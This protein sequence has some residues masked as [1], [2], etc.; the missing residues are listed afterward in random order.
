MTF[1]MNLACEQAA[2]IFSFVL[3][4]GCA[5]VGTGPVPL[6]PLPP[7]PGP[8]C[9]DSRTDPKGPAECG[10]RLDAYV[11]RN[12]AATVVIMPIAYSER[13]GSLQ[14]VGTGAVISADGLVLTAYHVIAGAEYIT[15]EIRSANLDQGILVI[16][17]KTIPMEIVGTWPERD[18]ALLRPRH[19]TTFPAVLRAD[20]NWR[21]EPGELLW[22]F[23]QASVG[24]RGAVTGPAVDDLQLQAADR[25]TRMSGL[26]IMSTACRNGDSGGPVVDLAGRLVGIALASPEK[27]ENPTYFL[28][29]SAIPEAFQNA[30]GNAELTPAETGRDAPE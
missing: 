19:P 6:Q 7:D 3:L 13:D 1:R 28:P 14:K 30:P 20:L 26:M 22:H 29:V 21:P 16:P 8:V 5:A 24:L 27:G 2:L 10:R 9:V 4:S 12:I 17:V 11:R 15:A 25:T 18:I 23:G